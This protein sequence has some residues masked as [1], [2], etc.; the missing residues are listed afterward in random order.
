MCLSVSLPFNHIEDNNDFYAA[1][2]ELSKS[3]AD[4]LRYLSE[5]VFHP[6]E[7]DFNGY[8]ELNNID[9]DFNFYNAMS[10]N[11]CCNYYLESSFNDM[12]NKS[13]AKKYLFPVSISTSGV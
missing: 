10:Q 3:T 5:K 2:H 12:I 4:S 1:V 8:E 7:S 6:F 13:K 9:P 11:R